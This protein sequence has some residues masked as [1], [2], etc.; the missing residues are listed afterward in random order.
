MATPRLNG[1]AINFLLKG[2]GGLVDRHFSPL[3]DNVARTAKGLAPAESGRLKGSIRVRRRVQGAN[4]IWNIG[5]PLRYAKYP[6]CGTG[7]YAGFGP[8]TPRRAPFLV[9]YIDGRKIVTRSVR[10][11]P[12][13]HFM[14]AALRTGQPYP[15]TV[16]PCY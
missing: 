13:Q 1:G 14:I 8:I 6:E 15:I 9:F 16:F 7:V 3:A 4:V 10:G 5:S 11:Q 2:R 12:A